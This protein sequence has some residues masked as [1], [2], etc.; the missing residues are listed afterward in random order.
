MKTRT[1][2]GGYGLRINGKV[3]RDLDGN[4][5]SLE[6]RE[7]LDQYIQLYLDA[8]YTQVEVIEPKQEEKKVERCV[9]NVNGYFT[10]IRVITG[11]K[12]GSLYQDESN[13]L[14]RKRSDVTLMRVA[15]DH[16]TVE[17]IQPIDMADEYFDDEEDDVT[18]VTDE[19]LMDLI[20]DDELV[21]Q[22]AWSEEVR[23]GIA[24]IR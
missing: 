22:W 3:W 16:E 1:N 6:T 21:T 11:S 15:M 14:F 7:E 20:D 2:N 10:I 13:N 18:V 17:S 12:R 24:R 23:N 8:G 5:R 9:A 4:P 19:E